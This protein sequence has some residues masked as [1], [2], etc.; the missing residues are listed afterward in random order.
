MEPP[1]S[2][3]WYIAATFRRGAGTHT[4]N[5]TPLMSIPNRRLNVTLPNEYHLGSQ[6][7]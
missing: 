7:R 1:L 6:D 3:A 4:D 2:E 5:G